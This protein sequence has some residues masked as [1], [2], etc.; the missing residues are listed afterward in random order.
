MPCPQNIFLDTCIF[1][2]QAYN[3]NS[4]AFLSFSDAAQGKELKLL[5]P[6]PTEREIRKHI[7]RNAR[8]A[9]TA[10]REA[11]RKAPFVSK[12]NRWPKE[13][14]EWTSEYEIRDLATAELDLFF[15]QSQFRLVKLGYEDVRLPEIM[16]WYQGVRP[17]FGQEKGKQK[18][19]PDALSSPH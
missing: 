18:E 16:D 14:S 6:D 7:T 15:S 10:L 4:A 5:L 11:K 1:D 9:L 13:Q 8:A 3:F 17:P 2:G 12:W 19:F